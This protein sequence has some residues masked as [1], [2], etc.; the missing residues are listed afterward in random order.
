[1]KRLRKGSDKPDRFEVICCGL[2]IEDRRTHLFLPWTNRQVE[3]MNQTIKEAI[4]HRFHYVT[5]GE[6]NAHLKVY[7]WAYNNAHPLCALEECPLWVH[8]RAP[9]GCH[10]SFHDAPTRYLP[11]T[12]MGHLVQCTTERDGHFLGQDQTG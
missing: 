3:S 1:M 9:A 8:S 11:G 5:L 10:E 4:I 7:Q 12:N 6:L 2:G